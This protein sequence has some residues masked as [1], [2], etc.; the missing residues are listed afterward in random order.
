VLIAAVDP[1]AE[2]KLDGL[3]RAVISG[4]YLAE[5]AGKAAATGAFPV[6]AS[7]LSGLD[8]AAVT[9]LATLSAPASPPSGSVSWM[10]Q[11]ATVPGQVISTSTTTADQ[12]YRRLLAA[13]AVKSGRPTSDAPPNG[14]TVTY[15]GKVSASS[16][17][18]DVDAYWSVGPTSYSRSRSGTLVAQLAHNP[19]S[20]WYTGGVSVVSMDDADN[21]YRK[22]EVHAPVN[23]TFTSLGAY[24]ELVGTFNPARIDEFDPLSRVP[25]GAY[26]P[27]IASPANRPQSRRCT[28]ATCCRIRIWADT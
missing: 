20:T 23:G 18:L 19:P 13:L 28:A 26:E 16:V 4:H 6:L 15:S 9:Q 14:G 24:P 21:Q 1:A 27:V 7:S 8:E 22:V 11:H 17:P 5:S 10:A 3:N 12:A 25:L 2:A